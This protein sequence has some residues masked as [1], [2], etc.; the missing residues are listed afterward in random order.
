MFY[1]KDG[2][3]LIYESDHYISETCKN[4]NFK[5]KYN[6]EDT[7]SIVSN[8]EQI[9]GPSECL[10][11]IHDKILNFPNK[12]VSGSGDEHCT[13]ADKFLSG[14]NRGV[15][16]TG[17][18]NGGNEV[19]KHIKKLTS[20][21]MEDNH[22]NINLINDL[23][24][25]YIVKNNVQ[26]VRL[27]VLPFYLFK[28]RVNSF[29][30]MSYNVFT[31]VLNGLYK[32]TCF[33]CSRQNTECT[34]GC[35]NYL[36]AIKKLIKQGIYCIIDI[37][38]NGYNLCSLNFS[39][40][41]TPM[42]PEAFRNMWKY[43]VNYILQTIPPEEHQYIIFELCNEPIGEYN[44]GCNPI[45]ECLQSANDES[46]DRKDC[47]KIY[48]TLYQIPTIKAIRDLE[49]QYKSHPHIIMVTTYNNWSGV[50]FWPHDGTLEQLAIDL[51]D[52]SYNNSINSKVIIA[53]H[54]YCDTD[55][56]GEGEG[57]DIDN[58]SVGKQTE[59]IQYVDKT[60]N[61]YN[62]KWVLTEGNVMNNVYSGSNYHLYSTWLNK[63]KD[64]SSNIGYTLWFM[65]AGHN[66]LEPI[67]FEPGQ[68]NA[69]SNS[70]YYS[71]IYKQQSNK[72]SY[73]PYDDL[74]KQ[75]SLP[76]YDFS[77]LTEG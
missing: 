49:D 75:Y 19:D 42:T 72:F 44:G 7:Y 24:I 20:S 46:D 21:I 71:K 36:Y 63:I 54:Q 28:Q 70:N 23:F 77:N 11:F 55:Y 30:E 32:S 52:S 69:P 50:H 51:K 9:E 34:D 33:D 57:C 16:I 65:N 37:H 64:S 26:I 27:P 38:S 66:E 14:Y 40:N 13:A 61:L 58:F 8:L 59:W 10:T 35:P 15:N 41:D 53:G 60:L 18:D 22:Y 74:D 2:S 62:L 45:N 1:Y 12:V 68:I 47:Q 17:F 25:T 3:G 48:D 73:T 67:G 39:T 76:V 56:S 4:I 5:L 31:P 29:N 6:N 43:I